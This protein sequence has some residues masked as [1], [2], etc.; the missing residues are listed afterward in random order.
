VA[1]QAVR[2]LRAYLNAASRL[3]RP[4]DDT[5]K[6]D[7]PPRRNVKRVYLCA[8]PAS[9]LTSGDVAYMELLQRLQCPF[10][11]IITKS[12]TVSVKNLARIVDYIRA[13]A[14]PYPMCTEIFMSSSLRLSGITKLQNQLSELSK[15]SANSVGASLN[16]DDFDAI[17]Q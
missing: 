14:V 7:A 13:Q 3:E 8:G 4:V 1:Q 6:H 11:I 12:D 17:I 9:G 2:M 5:I 16:L 10:G 15:S